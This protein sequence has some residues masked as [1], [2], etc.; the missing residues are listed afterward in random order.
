M[1]ENILIINK[2]GQFKRRYSQTKYLTYYVICNMIT[3]QKLNI[4]TQFGV[5]KDNF[6]RTLNWNETSGLDKNKTGDYEVYELGKTAFVVV[7]KDNKIVA[8]RSRTLGLKQ[9]QKYFN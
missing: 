5:E 9:V 3:K 7:D 6:I 1:I 8:V 4:Y 2:G